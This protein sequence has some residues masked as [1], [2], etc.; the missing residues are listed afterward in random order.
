[1]KRY[2]IALAVVLAVWIML[3]QAA[4]V[5]DETE[6]ALVLQFGHPVRM[7]Q[8]PGLH[9]KVPFAQ[10]RIL[11]ERRILVSDPAA[12]EYFDSDKKRLLVDHLTRWRISDPLRFYQSVRDELG[13]DGRLRPIIFSELRDELAR[14]TMDE[15]ISE[16]RE[17]I[18]DAMVERV[19]PKVAPFGIDIVDV[20]LKRVDLPPEVQAS[21]FARM[22][23]ERNRIALAYRADGEELAAIIRAEA[24]RARTVLLARAYE[25]SEALRGEGDAEAT[26]VY[27]EAFQKN[28]EFYQFIRSLEAYERFLS[29]N[30]AILMSADS[31]LFRYFVSVGAGRN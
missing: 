31:E 13:G 7:I 14:H 11:L 24:D 15:I 20:R 10:Q 8:E 1:M 18:M 16:K 5:V 12:G 23:A 27:A 21:V 3:T 29:Q 30:T 28:P 6:Q 25:Q 26:K 9:F 2:I 22:E 4:F 17:P 19:R